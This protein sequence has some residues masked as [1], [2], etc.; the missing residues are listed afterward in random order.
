[1][2]GLRSHMGNASP[3]GRGVEGRCGQQDERRGM[4]ASGPVGL[5]CE[6]HHGG[7]GHVQKEERVAGSSAKKR[8]SS[9]GNGRA[10][11]E[12]GEVACGQVSRTLGRD[13][14]QGSGL[15]P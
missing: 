12:D 4:Q 11:R 6:G 10:G 8:G 15:S 2:A 14:Q 3:E 13:G 1:M 5:H 7:D 9:G